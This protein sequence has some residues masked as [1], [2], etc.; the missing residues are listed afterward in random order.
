MWR[1][2]VIRLTYK[3]CRTW[4]GR[5]VFIRIHAARRRRGS[6]LQGAP[7]GGQTA[8]L[9]WHSRS[10]RLGAGCRRFWR[11][12]RA[13]SPQPPSG[14]TA[15]AFKLSIQL[16]SAC[17]ARLVQWPVYLGSITG[18]TASAMCFH[19]RGC[20]GFLGREN[21]GLQRPRGL[22]AGIGFPEAPVAKCMRSS[23]LSLAR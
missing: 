3:R 20:R 5:S 12:R 21:G 22:S 19:V 23:R 4:P 17:P 13:Y 14:T 16:P 6:R 18:L 2:T 9:C 15:R 11:I 10:R 7:F 1:G 8:R